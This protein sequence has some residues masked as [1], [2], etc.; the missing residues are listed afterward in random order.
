MEAPDKSENRVS[1]QAEP[2]AESEAEIAR[3]SE[4]LR[5]ERDALLRTLADFENYRRRT[6]RDRAAAAQSGNRDVIV[7]L[8][9]VLDDFDRALQHMDDAPPSVAQGMEAI[10]RNLIAV[11]ERN[12]VTRFNSVGE[13]FDPQWHDAVA[14]VA[15]GEMQPGTIAEELQSGYKWGEELLRPARVRVAQ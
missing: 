6:E 15:S 7:S 12:G 1:D 8:L 11:L 14:T 2:A 9:A 10:Q 4:E 3:L 13:A 5:R